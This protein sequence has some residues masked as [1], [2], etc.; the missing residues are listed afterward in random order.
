MKTSVINFQVAS[1]KRELW[2]GLCIG[3]TTLITCPW[4]DLFPLSSG[5][6]CGHGYVSCGWCNKTW[7]SKEQQQTMDPGYGRGH[8][9][10]LLLCER[11]EVYT[12]LPLERTIQV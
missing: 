9:P 4:S 8:P 1:L 6:I 10:L 7:I 2:M 12:S 3:S 11:I 5:S